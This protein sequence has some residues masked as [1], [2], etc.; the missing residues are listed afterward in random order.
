[1]RKNKSG[2]VQLYKCNDC[3]KIFSGIFGFR[4][5]RYSPAIVSEAIHLYH[6]GMSSYA[7]ADL[8]EARGID[9]TSSVIRKWV[10]RYFKISWHPHFRYTRDRLW[11]VSSRQQCVKRLQQGVNEVLSELIKN[12]NTI[13]SGKC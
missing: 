5:R 11:R 7:I 10:D 6:S 8:L 3:K 13:I 9:V 2:S 1:M 4:Y 12:S